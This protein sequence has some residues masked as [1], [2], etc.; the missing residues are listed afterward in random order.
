MDKNTIFLLKF[1]QKKSTS[2]VEADCNLFDNIIFSQ[3]RLLKFEVSFH[4]L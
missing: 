2:V 1:R 4:L 3:L